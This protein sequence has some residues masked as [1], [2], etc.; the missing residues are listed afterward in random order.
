MKLRSWSR[1]AASNLRLVLLRHAIAEEL[2]QAPSSRGRPPSDFDRRLTAPGRAK[3][4]RILRHYLRRMPAPGSLYSSPLLRARQT[5]LVASGL[6]H[7]PVQ[8]SE[9]LCPGGSACDWLTTVPVDDLMVVGH[10]PDLSRLAAEFLG[11]SRPLFSLK[12][13]GL[14]CLT[15]DIGVGRLEWLL[16]PRWLL[17]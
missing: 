11:L 1:K 8:L 10:E 17:D 6:L 16:T 9:A 14:A 5:A 15:G 7:L 4:R 2:S 3:L 12:K 13:A